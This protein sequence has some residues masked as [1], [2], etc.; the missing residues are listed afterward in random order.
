[1]IDSQYFTRIYWLFDHLKIT[2][3]NSYMKLFNSIINHVHRIR[4]YIFFLTTVFLTFWYKCFTI[5]VFL[6]IS[7]KIIKKILYQCF[8][9]KYNINFHLCQLGTNHI[10]FNGYNVTVIFFHFP[11]RISLISLEAQYYISNETSS[12]LK[13]F[14]LLISFNYIL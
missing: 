11:D 1:M 10:P 2:I 9:N 13:Y 5:S 8:K 4:Y 6:N 7:L 3:Y 14:N 12:N